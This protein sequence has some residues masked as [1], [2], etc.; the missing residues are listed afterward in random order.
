[1]KIELRAIC[2]ETLGD[3]RNGGYE[4]PE[5]SSA[6]NALAHCLALEGKTI[7]HGRLVGLMFMCNGKHVSSDTILAE[8][9]RL[10]VLRPMYGG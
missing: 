7:E 2:Q 5:H 9:D 6:L 8:G 10:T 1:M 3:L 4:V